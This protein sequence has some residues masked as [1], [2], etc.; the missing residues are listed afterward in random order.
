MLQK[1]NNKRPQLASLIISAAHRFEQFSCQIPG[2]LFDF[3][4]TTLNGNDFSA[5][6]ALAEAA[7]VPDARRRL[8][9]GEP[10]N[11]TENRAVLHTL[12]RGRN[13]HQLLS[14]T[15][16][17]ECI[18]A[19]ERMRRIATAMHQGH[20]PSGESASSQRIRHVIHVG[21]G[22]SLLGPRLL[23]HAFPGSER[24]PEVHFISS[25]DAWERER[26]LATIDPRETAIILVSKSFATS[27]VLSH[28]RRL[29]QW[30]N[31]ALDPQASA[32]RLF[33]V[34]AAVDKAIAFGVSESQIMQMGEWT[35]GRYSLWSPVSLAAAISM[36]PAAFDQLCAG[37]ASMDR[38]FCEAHPVDNLPLIHG[39]LSC[40][41]RNVCNYPCR[42]LIPYGS[43]LQGLP[44]WLQQVQME[45]NGKSVSREGEPLRLETSPLVFGD[46]GTDA[47]HALFQAFHQGTAVVPLDFIGVIRPDHADT[48][49]QAE[50]LSHL[51]AQASALALGRGREETSAQMVSEGK[52]PGQIEQLLPHRIMPGSRP[53]SIFLIDELTPENLGKM[54][55][56]YE[57]SVFVESVVWNINAFDQW[58]VELGKVMA[59]SIE[60]ALTGSGKTTRPGIP[61]LDGL[62]AHIRRV[63]QG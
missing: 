40:W 45:S 9:A 36:G 27:E 46:C 18:Q 59:S 55:A 3:S 5:L 21:I 12:W 38:H 8:F 63:W 39:L 50:L 54:L 43:R 7:G 15:E 23:C 53:S 19:L 37:G 25:V 6:F 13:F 34:T 62:V 28:A 58:G 56:L 20:L 1:N 11:N 4:R 24:A 35:G 29:R 22:G 31:S 61:G 26:L 16:A 47:Q 51:L 41:H 14:K 44:A 49:A 48:A 32:Q 33:A 42:A 57:H 52:S 10:I 60:P 30:Q 17:T 2:L